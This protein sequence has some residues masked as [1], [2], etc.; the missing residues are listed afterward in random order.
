MGGG[1]LRDRSAD[2]EQAHTLNP[3]SGIEYALSYQSAAQGLEQARRMCGL[4]VAGRAPSR[5]RCNHDLPVG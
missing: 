2:L 4:T 1:G 5:R 3:C